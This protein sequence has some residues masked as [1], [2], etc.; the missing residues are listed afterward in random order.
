MKKNNKEIEVND[1]QLSIS[2]IIVWLRLRSQN[3]IDKS[4]RKMTL[5]I[6]SFILMTTIFQWVQSIR[7]YF[8]F[9]KINFRHHQPIFIL[10]HWR[11]GTTH[12]HYLMA[13]D[14]QWGIL[15][16]Y[17]A[18]LCRVSLLGGRLLMHIL[19]PLMPEKRPQDNVAMTVYEPAEEE[20]P[21]T[22]YTHRSGMQSF[23]FPKNISYYDKYNLFKGLNKRQIKLWK[24]DY[25]RLLKVISHFNNNKPLLLK[26]PHNTS[27]GKVLQ[28]MFP[29]AKFVFIYR[30]PY[31]VYLSTKHLYKKTIS[32][33]FLQEFSDDEIHER[34]MY[35]Y[36]TMLKQYIEHKKYISPENIIEIQ[37]EEL[38]ENPYEIMKRIYSTLNIPGYEEA[39]PN[40]TEYLDSV[41][42]YKKNTFRDIAPHIVKEIN[43]RWDFSFQEWGYEKMVI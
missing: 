23:F 5:K 24:R 7:Y 29:K 12:L 30:N 38:E 13:R 28:E 1:H 15:S 6:W 42:D 8:R 10:G 27:R 9:Q 35:C 19:A 18:L 41:K 32:T 39:L 37:Y 11:S 36:E 4:Y 14:Q 21:L 43:E 26:N 34:I 40:F 16:N 2:R 33:Q 31:D 22:N 25:L 20:Q 3:K 17:Q